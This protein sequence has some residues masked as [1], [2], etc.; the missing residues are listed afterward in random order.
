MLV[1]VGCGVLTLSGRTLEYNNKPGE[2]TRGWGK[3]AFMPPY[4]LVL[5]GGIII[6][7]LRTPRFVGDIAVADGKIAAVGTDI[8]RLW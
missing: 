3:E 6:D 8:A 7:G 4:D 1:T 2:N 5:Q